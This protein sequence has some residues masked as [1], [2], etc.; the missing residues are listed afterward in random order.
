MGVTPNRGIPYP[1]L[2]NVPNVPADMKAL[3]EK[4]DVELE[5]VADTSAA[6]LGDAIDK[7][8]HAV[9]AIG[10]DGTFWDVWATIPNWANLVDNHS[11]LQNAFGAFII[12][13]AG[14]YTTSLNLTSSGNVAIM[15]ARIRVA[16]VGTPTTWVVRATGQDYTDG[17]FNGIVNITIGL[18]LNVGDLVECQANCSNG[19]STINAE[20]SFSMARTGPL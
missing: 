6:S 5:G 2:D 19:V 16:R 17:Q 18:D 15:N 10:A 3:A 1:E 20:T 9:R 7:N 13:E 12:K 4:T 14:W 11:L 8:S